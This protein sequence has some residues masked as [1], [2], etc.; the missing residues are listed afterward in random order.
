[1]QARSVPEAIQHALDRLQLQRARSREDDV[2]IGVEGDA[3]PYAGRQLRKDARGLCRTEH[4]RN[5]V[6]NQH[7][8]QRGQRVALP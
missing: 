3:V 6:H 8:K 1:M 5:Y 2:V 7:K 4:S